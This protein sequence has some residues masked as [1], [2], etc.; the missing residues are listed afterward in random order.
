MLARASGM[1]GQ[2]EGRLACA[3]RDGLLR[4]TPPSVML[5]QLDLV[6]GRGGDSLR[7]A[8]S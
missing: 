8:A 6:A 7:G 1:L 5:R 4:A 2:W 3:A